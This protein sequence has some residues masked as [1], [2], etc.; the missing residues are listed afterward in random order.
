[1]M[2]NSPLVS[3]VE[4]EDDNLSMNTH[5]RSQSRAETVRKEEDEET[6]MAEFRRLAGEHRVPTGEHGGLIAVHTEIEV[7]QEERIEKVMGL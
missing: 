5:A 3:R 7:T 2:K 6:A 1:M 4:R